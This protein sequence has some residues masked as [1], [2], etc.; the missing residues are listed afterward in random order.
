MKSSIQWKIVM[1]YLC[2]VLIIMITCGSFIVLKIEQQQYE[3]LDLGGTAENLEAILDFES[4]T[5]L[6]AESVSEKLRD[7]G[8]IKDVE[9]YILTKDGEVIVSGGGKFNKSDIAKDDTIIEAITT[10]KPT[11]QKWEHFAKT[12]IVPS[13]GRLERE[14]YIGHATP[15]IDE[16]T[17]DILAIIY[18]VANTTQ[19]YD[20]ILSIMRTISV[21]SIIAMGI[22]AVLGALFSR[23]ITVPIKHLTRSAKQLASGSFNRIPIYSSDEIGQLTQSFNYMATE[24]SRTMGDISSEK[25]KLE[26]ILENMADGVMAFNRQGVLIH[27]NS[28]CYDMLGN[29]NMDHRF[30]FIFPKLGVEVSFD[31]ILEEL[32]ERDI[33]AIMN[34]EERYYNLHFAPYTNVLGEGEGVV[35][36][37]QDVTKQHK[38]DH[39]RKEFV[40]NV[41]HELRTPLTTVKSYTETLLDGAIDDREV[42]IS[43]L[44]VMEKEADRMTMLV[45]DLLELSK[46]DNKQ[47]QLNAAVIDLRGLIEDTIAAQRI[48]ADKKGHELVFLS[49][50]DEAYEI[51]GDSSRIRQI[52]HNIIS[53]AI[54]YSV[55]PGSITI[56]LLKDEAFVCVKV[57]D[58][59]IGIPKEDLDRIFERFYRVDKAR[60]RKMGGTGLGL[61]IAKEM[62]ELHGG[63]INIESTIG[64]GTTVTISFKAVGTI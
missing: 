25:S 49:A 31:T 64:K 33:E 1:I 24:L 6:D 40:A 13:R 11:T 61:A 5:W 51:M 58:T 9:I 55:D 20:N 43:F 2:V 12:K 63:K 36:V 34:L 48:L 27:A 32:V 37:M 22:A 41:S 7:I 45:K 42:A 18:V 3:N 38:L 50:Q 29:T 16:N 15:V 23:M 28:V 8:K 26:K 30:D 54:K 19:I 53:N 62:I 4:D 44:Q 57:E 56:R 52:L 10:K 59:G 60:S 46:I 14:Q 17:K 21:G 35:V 39:M 47:I